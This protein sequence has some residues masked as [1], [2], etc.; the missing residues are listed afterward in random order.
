M[1]IANLV[2][3]LSHY[4]SRLEFLLGIQ[5]LNSGMFW[6]SPVFSKASL[7]SAIWRNASRYVAS[8]FTISGYFWITLLPACVSKISGVKVFRMPISFRNSGMK[9]G[10][11]SAAA[12]REVTAGTKLNECNNLNFPPRKVLGFPSQAAPFS[13]CR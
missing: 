1:E 7:F 13:A 5:R 2:A 8:C 10:P 11:G 4:E 9:S 6:P 3:K 12:K